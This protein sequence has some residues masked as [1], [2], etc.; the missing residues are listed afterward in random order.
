MDIINNTKIF[1]VM[2]LILNTCRIKSGGNVYYYKYYNHNYKL[3]PLKKNYTFKT[4]LKY[5]YAR[6]VYKIK[7]TDGETRNS[8]DPRL[9]FLLSHIEDK[10]FKAA[11]DLILIKEYKLDHN[12]YIYLDTLVDYKYMYLENKSLNDLKSN[13]LY[14]L[15]ELDGNTD[16][17][18]NDILTKLNVW[19]NG[20]ILYSAFINH[21]LDLNLNDDVKKDM[22]KYIFK[23]LI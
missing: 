16:Q 12:K 2:T 7:I 10:Y 17:F 6:N 19:A 15:L 14:G 8:I 22:L 20:T 4:L 21:F 13:H 18:N 3:K 11:Y 1:N 23:R 5:T 9:E